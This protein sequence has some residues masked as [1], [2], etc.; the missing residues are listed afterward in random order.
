MSDDV[1]RMTI[2]ELSASLRAGELSSYEIV[3]A[4]LDRISRLDE[5]LGAFV[6]TFDEEARRQA[7]VADKILE[8]GTKVGPLHG[9]PIAI[10][11]VFHF[12]GCPTRAGSNAFELSE[13][14]ASAHAVS[15]LERAGMIILGKTNTQEFAYGGWGTNTITGTPWN[16]WDREI[17]RVPGGSS[18]GSAVAVAA[19]LVPAALG[20]DTGGSCRGPAAYCGC[21]GYKPS[22]GLIG[23]TGM[24]PLSPTI[25]V[26]G[27]LT[28][29]TKDA[30]L[31]LQ[32]LAGRDDSDEATWSAPVLSAMLSSGSRVEG[33]RIGRLTAVDDMDVHPDV[34]AQ[35]NHTLEVAERHGATVVE[36]DLPLPLEAYLDETVQLVSAEVYQAIGDLAEAADSQIQEPVRNRIL[37]GRGLGQA[38]RVAVMSRRSEAIAKMQERMADIDI[39]M[40]PT[41]AQPAIPVADVDEKVPATPFTRIGNYLDLVGLAI[42]TGVT[43]EGLPIS[44]QILTNRFQD[45]L[46]FR[47]GAFFESVLP[48]PTLPPTGWD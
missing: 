21:V 30:V 22:F 33:L 40:T 31:L 16:P 12:T 7:Q 47:V 19:G 44:V 28:R 24:I 41:C 34:L 35:Y 10:K 13:S 43:S 5:R 3:S 23:R 14:H 9:I 20:S 42:P 18:S 26:V 2:V 48:Q 37:A 4:F 36:F 25:D 1:S 6:Q 17:H 46:A 8:S 15:K 29:S 32:A 27:T 11:D 45:A 39:L 38:D